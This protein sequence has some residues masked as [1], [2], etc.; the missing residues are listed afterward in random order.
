MLGRQ[1]EYYIIVLTIMVKGD[2]ET[3]PSCQLLL[4][5]RFEE[6]NSLDFILSDRSNLHTF[7]ILVSMCLVTQLSSTLCDPMDCARQA[8][9]S[10]WFSR[11]I[12]EWVAMPFSSVPSRPSDQTHLYVGSL[13]LSHLGLPEEHVCVCVCACVCVYNVLHEISRSNTIL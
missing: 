8:S 10:M 4:L 5:K 1:T 6:F 11:L 13:S 3:T 12:L 9:L 2:Q 7:Q